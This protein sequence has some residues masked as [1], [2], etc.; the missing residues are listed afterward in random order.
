MQDD[1]FFIGRWRRVLSLSRLRKLSAVLSTLALPAWAEQP[2]GVT[3]QALQ[4]PAQQQ[5]AQATAITPATAAPSPSPSPSPAT[6]S[7]AELAL[8]SAI[9]N[10]RRAQGRAEWTAE[11]RLAAVARAHSQ[12]MAQHGQF[13]HDGFKSRAERT[14]SALCVE[15][16]LH[17][18][19]APARAVLLWTA[20]DV[21]HG[22]LLESGAHAAGI[23]MAGRFVTMLACATPLATPKPASERHKPAFSGPRPLHPRPPLHIAPHPD[24][25]LP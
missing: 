18:A 25:R 22:N 7:T 17:G 11:P 20:S 12:A 19:V 2:P 10:Y 16:L 24:H 1:P 9:N 14:G 23:G 21:H 15:N 5:P 6:M 8:L 4:A 3:P 13:S